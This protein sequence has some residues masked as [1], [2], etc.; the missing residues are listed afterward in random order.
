MAESDQQDS[1]LLSLPGEIRNRIYRFIAVHQEPVQIFAWPQTTGSTIKFSPRIPAL[2]I[3]CKTTYEEIKAIFYEENTFRFTEYSLNHGRLE[4]FRERAG[5]SA[6]KLTAIKITRVYGIGIFG[7]TLSFTARVTNAGITISDVSYCYVG[8]QR[9]YNVRVVDGV[10]LCRT[11]K[12]AG[13]S[14]KPLLDFLEEYLEIDGRWK[15]STQRLAL[16][17]SCKKYSIVCDEHLRKHSGELTLDL[18]GRLISRAG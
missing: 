7:C 3:A 8:G 1:R 15:G 6:S 13:M 9:P 2:A 17:T 10:C 5:D 4:T 11:R 14:T 16:C 12:L 18:R